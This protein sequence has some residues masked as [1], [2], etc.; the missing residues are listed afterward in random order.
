[1]SGWEAWSE[2]DFQDVTVM[3]QKLFFLLVGMNLVVFKAYGQ[4]F[5]LHYTRSGYSIRGQQVSFEKSMQFASMYQFVSEVN[6]LSFEKFKNRIDSQI[7]AAC[8]YIHKWQEC[9]NHFRKKW[10]DVFSKIESSRLSDRMQSYKQVGS[11]SEGHLPSVFEKTEGKGCHAYNPCGDSEIAYAIRYGSK[12]IF[13][14]IYNKIQNKPQRCYQ[15]ILTNLAQLLQKEDPFPKQCV[16][17]QGLKEHFFCQD[18]HR[19]ADTLTDRILKIQKL[20]YRE[21]VQSNRLPCMECILPSLTKEDHLGDLK[22]MSSFLESR[23][24]CSDLKKGE[25]RYVTS[26]THKAGFK[27][28]HY[29]IKKEPDGTYSIPLFLTFKPDADYDGEV[30][31]NEAP[32]HYL[33]KTKKCLQKASEKM[34][35]PGGKKLQ[36]QI[37]APPPPS[38]GETCKIPGTHSIRVGSRH[39]RDTS[40]KY[41]SDSSCDVITHE[42]LHLLGLPD[43]YEETQLGYYVDSQTGE[44]VSAAEAGK[45]KKNYVIKKAYDCRIINN[46]S[47]MASQLDR[48][49]RAFA[50]NKEDSLLN[51]EHFDAIVYGACSKNRH[52]NECARLHYTSSVDDPTCLEKK[53]Q[54]EERAHHHHH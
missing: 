26:G 2:F 25:T 41:S 15:N 43:E 17:S 45:D 10:A 13:N 46:N 1:M 7:N 40:K 39:H 31:M 30:P 34:L 5:F 54:C 28:K 48:W 22:N 3:K 9:R 21:D 8:G 47:I 36:I 12:D 16:S 42:V 35:G 44:V 52:Y 4:D 37:Q 23:L 51:P 53:R 32:S 19:T 49:N 11:L 14:Q 29:H 38:E 50:T 18:I 33:Q 20:F 27:P 6:L 24:L